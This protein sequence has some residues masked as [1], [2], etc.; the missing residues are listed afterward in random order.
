MSPLAAVPRFAPVSANVVVP[1]MSP[2][3]VPVTEL[4]PAEYVIEVADEIRD[5]SLKFAATLVIAPVPVT[6]S[7]LAKVMPRLTCVPSSKL[8]APVRVLVELDEPNPL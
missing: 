3:A 8:T 5:V 4:N 7:T 6:L 2:P 1:V